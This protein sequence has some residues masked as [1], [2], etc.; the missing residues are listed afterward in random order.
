[1][2]ER[3]QKIMAQAG[4]GS[5]RDC[6][7]YIQ[8]GR[9]RVNGT[10]AVIGQKANPAVDKITLDGRAVKPAEQKIYV[11][12]HKPRYVLSTV[13]PEQGDS[14]QTVRDLI[15]VTERL[16][17][18]GRLDFE[19]EGLVLMTNDGDLAQKLTHPSHG[20]S[21]EYRVLLARHPDDEQ[22]ATWRRGVVLEDGYKT[23]PA[24]I[25]LES[26]A[27]K[28]AWVRIVMRE[29]RKRQIRE[30]G[31]ILALP[32]VRILRVRIGNLLLGNLKPGEWR[33]LTSTEITALKSDRPG[34]PPYP[35]MTR[36]KP[37]PGAPRKRFVRGRE[38][39]PAT[40]GRPATKPEGQGRPEGRGKPEGQSRPVGRG[41]PEGQSRPVGRGRPSGAGKPEGQ[42]QPENRQRP[43]GR[44]KPP[45]GKKSN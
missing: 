18:V 1:M 36:K 21:K 38:T 29:G 20:H 9:V 32:V 23:Q 40:G 35:D 37:L 19:S 4:L 12:L 28:G 43:T 26:L 15:P 8:A 41:K 31:A 45:V 3:L 39:P 7:E 42:G 25:R 34:L 16:Y 11:A 10:V 27:G 33:Y 22:L 14:R 6:E 5:R 30:I 17:P 44:H 24:E 2:E 13:E